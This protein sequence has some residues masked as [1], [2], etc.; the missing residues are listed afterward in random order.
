MSRAVATQQVA[1]NPPVRR[2]DAEAKHS[3]TPS[4][5]VASSGELLIQ[6]KAGCACGGGCPRCEEESAAVAAAAQPK[7][8]ISTP[9][10]RYEQEA[11][12]VADEIMRMPATHSATPTTT[13]THTR[14]APQLVQRKCSSCESA[15][16]RKPPE[17]EERRVIQTK[18]ASGDSSGGGTFA[19]HE[20]HSELSAQQGGG[21]SLSESARSFFEP[22]FGHDFANVR[23]HTDS[24]AD[25]MA[26]SIN[27][28]A[29]TIGQDIAFRSGEYAPDSFEGKKLLAHE[30]AHTLQQSAPGFS[31]QVQRVCDAAT[32]AH[33]QPLYFPRE[34]RLSRVFAGRS[35]LRP[36]DRNVAVG[37]VQQALVDLCFDLGT[38]G[39]NADGVD[40]V[41]H[42]MTE[43]AV[44]DFQT[45]ESVPAATPGIVD[46][47]TLRCLDGTRS[48]L[49]V[50]CHQT[51]VPDSQFQITGQR[52][53]GRTE[54]IFFER[55][56]STLDSDDR[57]K[58]LLLTIL[59][60]GC[61]LTL[62]GYESEDELVEFGPQLATDRINAVDAE[63]AARN[64]D[65]PGP[66]CAP[67]PPPAPPLRTPV[68][69]PDASAGVGTYRDRRKVEVIPAGTSTTTT[70]CSG[71][72]VVRQRPL[73]RTETPIVN[74]AIRDGLAMMDAALAALVPGNVDGDNALNSFFGGVAQRTQVVDN[75][76]IWRRHLNRV[77]RRRKQRGTDC[78]ATC[79]DTTAY[80]NRTGG[81][82]MMTVCSPFFGNVNI[83]PALTEP[84]NRALV[85]VHEA[86]HGSLDTTDVAY[87]TNRLI[88]FIGRSPTLAL[89]NTDS[90]VTLIR[91]LSGTL[92]G[93]ALPPGG[94]TQANMTST[95][96]DNAQEGIAWLDSWL[97]WAEQDLSGLYETLNRSRLRG[98]LVRGYYGDDVFAP[99]A[100]AFNLRRPSATAPPTMREQTEVAS[101]WHRFRM[102]SRIVGHDLTVTKDISATP[103]Q[104]WTRGA[105]EAPGTS[106]FLTD[107]YFLTATTPRQRVEMLLSMIIA[108]TPIIDASVRPAYANFVKD[109][110]RINWNNNP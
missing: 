100:A 94:D 50:P 91:C 34:S 3:I 87:D 41:Y 96:E 2:R 58:I 75:L 37:L 52:T 16:R 98:R 53:I 13:P 60:Q 69:K 61:A 72:R 73:D 17:E 106:V 62:E 89:T 74:T 109:T 1:S 92:S 95:E 20:L 78:D 108:A 82:A 80:N 22:R 57:D 40:N 55:G 39:A 45:A 47:D 81:S 90:Y 49:T 32:L 7:L 110:V 28:R 43:Q 25:S 70:S 26:R 51:T 93:C 21:A 35:R 33:T 27:A 48:Q 76:R 14:A 12:R 85:L 4:V 23:V 68:P 11:D 105:I 31:R 18:K 30:L 19:P 107:T 65:A 42:P 36:G 46:R 102:M 66:L 5:E 38:T 56:S 63:F 84:Q 54:D 97:T 24:R 104:R 9:G 103:L 64:Q 71:R 6:R 88:H 10:D 44:R 79:S 29:F 101:I 77:V 99:F 83:Y 67:P 8:R 15:A 86:G 59:N